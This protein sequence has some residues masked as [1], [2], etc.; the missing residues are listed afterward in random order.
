ML[1]TSFI[2]QWM[3]R[4]QEPSNN[5]YH[6]SQQQNTC[7]N[8]NNKN[9]NSSTQKNKQQKQQNN[10]KTT[11]KSNTHARTPTRTHAHTQPD[12]VSYIPQTVQSSKQSTQYQ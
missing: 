9:N 7:T 6:H 10:D 4:K 12:E 3:D 11:I 1:E 2:D 5:I 8:K